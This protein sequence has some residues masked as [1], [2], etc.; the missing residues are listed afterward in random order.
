MNYPTTYILRHRLE[1]LKKC[2][3]RGLEGRPDLIFLT[4]PT[5]KLPPL[6]N[7]CILSL[8][9]PPLSAADESK[10]ILLLDATWR[11]AAKM[12]QII[13]PAYF[14]NF[15]SIPSHFFTSYPRKQT[16]CQDPKRGLASIEALYLAY[17]ILG[18]PTTGLL[19]NYYWKTQFLE[20]NQIKDKN[21]ST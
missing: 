17:Y 11:Y 9:G 2:S 21:Y 19:D 7:M 13:D 1:N 18:R 12:A 4:Y 5:S 16:E 15:R 6:N 3:L 8:D 14:H 20:N 10:E